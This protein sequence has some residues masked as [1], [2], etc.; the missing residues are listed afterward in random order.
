VRAAFALIPL[1]PLTAWAQLTLVVYDG[2]VEVPIG[3]IFDYGKIA[4][5][6]ARD[7]RF[8]ARNPG[9]S[10]VMLTTLSVSGAGFGFINP[11][12]TPYTIASGNFVEFPVRFSANVPA[13]YSANLQ[14][15][16]ISVLLLAAAGSVPTL[17]AVSG[18]TGPDQST[19]TIDFGRI[20]KGSASTCTLALQNVSTQSQTVSALV[21]SGAGFGPLQ[22]VRAP[23]TLLPGERV[24]FTIAFAP[25]NAA[26]YSGTLNVDARAFP[27]TAAAFNPLLPKPALTFESASIGSAQQHTLKIS[28]ASPAPFAGFGSV[29][30]SF[31][32]VTKLITND[33]GL[34]FLV[35]GSRF[36]PFSFKQ[37]DTQISLNGLPSAVF[38]TGTSAGAI[39]FELTPQ[40][41]QFDA[42]PSLV[43][44][45][46]P[47]TI[48]IDSATAARGPDLVDIQITGYD[49]TYSAGAMSF[50][51]YDTSG[52]TIAPGAIQADFSPAFK[53]YFIRLG[54]GSAFLM[55]VTFPV[56]GTSAQIALVAGVDVTLT[57]SAGIA[58][59]QRLKFP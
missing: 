38:Q 47:A 16:G 18:C 34:I 29:N 12:Q 52:N 43:V 46:A 14:V 13:S 44:N 33:P 51:F 35:N 54:G 37:G 11:P 10:S 58:Q 40:G 49:N 9:A 56:T 55:H 2:A 59:T 26:V 20:A 28:L 8:R 4:A 19:R 50:V 24:T 6:D 30:L 39:A 7:V 23:L 41:F 25:P 31:S 42:D 45:I 1:L 27:L 5:G 21:V 3:S 32:P 17:A 48:G 53:Q 57:N 36:L 15:N 22:G